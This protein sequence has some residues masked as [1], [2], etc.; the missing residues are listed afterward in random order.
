M[1]NN[2][3]NNIK[4]LAYSAVLAAEETLNSASGQEKKVSAVNYVVSM[5]PVH[6]LFKKVITTFLSKFIDEAIENAVMYMKS[7]KNPEV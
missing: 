4:E 5:L 7:I 1:F 3:K 6:F 2:L